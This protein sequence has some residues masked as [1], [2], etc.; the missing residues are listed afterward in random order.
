MWSYLDTFYVEKDKILHMISYVFKQ[1]IYKFILSFMSKST[2]SMRWHVI[3]LQ[4]ALP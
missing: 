3:I 2:V 1:Q 4:A